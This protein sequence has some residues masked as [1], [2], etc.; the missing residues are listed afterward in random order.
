MPGVT[1]KVCSRIKTQPR[2]QQQSQEQDNPFNASLDLGPAK[3]TPQ[4]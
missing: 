2:G 3:V 1:K 4:A